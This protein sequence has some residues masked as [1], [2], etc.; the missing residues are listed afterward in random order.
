MTRRTL[1]LGLVVLLLVGGAAV[2]KFMPRAL[3]YDECSPVYRHFAD[4]QMEGVR[5]T[6]IKD[7]KI[8][9][10]LRLPVTLIEAETDR[11]WEQL[12][13][14]FGISARRKEILD[15]PD[16]PDDI[17]K[18]FLEVAPGYSSFYSHVETPE[19]RIGQGRC[20]PD[21]LNVYI[22]PYDRRIIIFESVNGRSHIEAIVD[23][24]YE[25]AGV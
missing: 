22:F 6:Y 4:M 11:G 20:H 5:I 10:T 2:W 25:E 9:D 14:L 12:D 7:K 16:I 21:D 3:S 18:D 1:I 8:N 13:S 24:A 17:K 15:N 19:V 23:A